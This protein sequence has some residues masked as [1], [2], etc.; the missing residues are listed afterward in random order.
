[1]NVIA[2]RVGEQERQAMI[3]IDFWGRQKTR[4]V[5]QLNSAYNIINTMVSLTGQDFSN[6]M[7]VYNTKFQ[8]NMAIYNAFNEEKRYQDQKI[9]QQ[10][11]F[12]FE[13][14]YKM[15]GLSLDLY[16]A[17]QSAIARE[18][19]SATA[20]L[21]IYAGLIKD[22]SL[23][24]ANLDENTKLS[25]QKM[26]IQSGLG[27]GFLSKITKDNPNGEIMTTTTRTDAAGN[28]YADTLIR[29]PDGSIKVDTTFLGKEAVTT[30]STSTSKTTTGSTGLSLTQ[31]NKYIEDA[32]KIL[33]DTDVRGR[34]AAGN[35]PYDWEGQ[36]D[37]YVLSKDEMI[38]A[39]DR[40]IGLIGDEEI[41]M[42]IFQQAMMAG[43]FTPWADDPA[44]NQ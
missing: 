9:Q 40:I 35:A 19:S 7:S 11:E 18:Q 38:Q 2:G 27:T 32:V 43:G 42:Q 34:E 17:E 39:R 15:A 5:N 30:K 41:G 4:A 16:Q 25:I 28:K 36:T 6:A 22:G 3:R 23:D 1:M 8:Q 44:W 33:T 13:S 14:Q 29:N 37:D 31:E 21:Q 10:K 26:E 20:N 24:F 12:E